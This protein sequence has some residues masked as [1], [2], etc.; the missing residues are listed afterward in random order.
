M[1]DAV[2]LMTSSTGVDAVW[3]QANHKLT[4]NSSTYGSDAFVKISVKSDSTTNKQFSTGLSGT[5]DTGT[6][7]VGNINGYTAT[8]KGNTL[9]INTSALAMSVTMN[10]PGTTSLAG[11]DL[12]LSITG[13]GALFQLG[14]D[15]NS[16]NQA[17]MGIQSA[18]TGNLGGVDGLLYQLKSGGGLSLTDGDLNASTK[19][20]DEALNQVTSLSGRLGAFQSSTLETNNNTLSS[21]VTALTSAQSSIQDAD[22]AAETANMTRAQILVQS[23][24]A[25]LKIAN[26]NP[27][28][29]LALL[30]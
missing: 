4:F 20:V 30:Q 6:D 13:G 7:I 23:G 5:D 1:R 16:N 9:S 10:N 21:T 24:T 27:Q 19:I 8:G 14:T 18:D 17:Y 29:V 3:D 25:V 28:N 11:K 22:F 26:Q 12:V 15:I 2:K